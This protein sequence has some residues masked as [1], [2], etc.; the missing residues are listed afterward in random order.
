MAEG[1]LLGNRYRLDAVVGRGG[2]GTVWRA[3]DVMLDREVAVKEVVL[4]PGLSASERDVLYERTFREARASARL[5]HPGVVVVHDVVEETGRPWIVMELVQARSL[6]DMIEEGL[7]QPREVAEIG[8][9][10]LKALRHAH[11]KGILHR[12]IKPSNV[13]I[14][15]AGRVVL[16]DFG[17]AQVEG[18]ATL[19]Q[20]GLVMGSP[21]YI[22]PE[23]AQ[24]ERAVP[25]SDLW[26]LGATMYAA[27][28]GRSPYERADAMASLAAALAEPVPPP[29]N[30]GP[31]NRVLEG[32]LA[33]EP[34]NRM[35]AAQA[36]P[37]LTEVATMPAPAP[38]APAGQGPLSITDET[39]MDEPPAQFP[40]AASAELPGE[41][42]LDSTEI[43]A[44]TRQ[45][46]PHG[47]PASPPSGVQRPDPNVSADPESRTLL[48]SNWGAAPQQSH[49]TQAPWEALPGQWTQQ[50]TPAPNP[51]RERT[52]TVLIVVLAVVLVV[53]AVLVGAVILRQKLNG[54][55]G[56]GGITGSAQATK[57]IQGVGYS[58]TVPKDWAFKNNKDGKPQLQSP[59]GK[60]F[61]LADS[62]SWVAANPMA[63]A[64]LS[65]A[66]APTSPR[67]R[68]NY[69]PVTAP[70]P[71]LYQG[72]QAAD[73]EFTFTELGGQDIHVKDRFVV[74]NGVQWAIYFRTPAADWAKMEQVRTTA[75]A[76][77]KVS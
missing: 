65:N 21:A 29:R 69:K 53:A 55:N 47:G 2:M 10:M 34:V 51:R 26:A 40:I 62:K 61:L 14:T 45:D 30:A 9:Q 43:E 67:I 52:K 24:G 13:L 27:L 33:R 64:Q 56:P 5:N 57:V 66:Q 70:A 44:A 72:H 4:P 42:V 36:A 73:W 11:E 7:L 31:L 17:I 19:T 49:R 1:H 59:D 35:N 54:S 50:P 23:R 60:S 25:A 46:A 75:F 63:Q 39:M 6:Q 77:F 12:D 8:L 38:K 68:R 58:V 20:T 48:E 74:I 41:T 37:L 18:D 32:L 3:Y 28:E 16:T 71:V 15:D 22:P 76:T